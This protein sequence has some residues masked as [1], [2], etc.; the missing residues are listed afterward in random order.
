MKLNK[1]IILTS[2]ADKLI[3]RSF[4]EVS[5]KP[6]N[7]TISSFFKIYN[8]MFFRIPKNGIES[9]T[10]IFN[11]TGEYLENPETSNV[12]E[13]RKLNNKITEIQSKLSEIE[14]QNEMLKSDNQAKEAEIRELKQS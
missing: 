3:D 2:E 13:I 11:K 6:A 7:M 9:H 1:K 4:K 5:S 8:N 14:H 10:T 12:K